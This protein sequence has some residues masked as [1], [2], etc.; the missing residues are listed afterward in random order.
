MGREADGGDVLGVA[1]KA[2]ALLREEMGGDGKRYEEGGRGDFDIKVAGKAPGVWI[3]KAVVKGRGEAV[4]EKRTDG[5]G[6]VEVEEE[7]DERGFLQK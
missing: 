2:W 6:G 1:W 7:V 5:E 4:A 3:D